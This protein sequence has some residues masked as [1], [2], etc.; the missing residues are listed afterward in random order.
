[1]AYV[2]SIGPV[3]IF[4]RDHPSAPW[5][6]WVQVFYAPLGFACDHS[7]RFEHGVEVYMEWCDRR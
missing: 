2:L 7:K 6:R 3:A 1:V 5:G 4:Q